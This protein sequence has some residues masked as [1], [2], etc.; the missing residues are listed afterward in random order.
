MANFVMLMSDTN[1]TGDWDLY[2]QKLI[3]SGKFRGGTSLGHGVR[4][5]RDQ[6]DSACTVT[7]IIRLEVNNLDEAKALLD[8]N[9]AYEAGYPVELLEEIEE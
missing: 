3:S 4:V 1:N 8:G 2:I 9:P 7:G 6:G 5:Q